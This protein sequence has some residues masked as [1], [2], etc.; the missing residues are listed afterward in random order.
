MIK[1]SNFILLFFIYIT[2]LLVNSQDIYV[3][4]NVPKGYSTFD[5]CGDWNTPC[6]SIEDAGKRAISNSIASGVDQFITIVGNVD[7]TTSASFSNL[8]KY[9]GTLNI[10]SYNNVPVTIDGSS[11]TTPFITIEENEVVSC[12]KKRRYIFRFLQFENWDQTLAKIN[13]NQET[14]LASIED[15]KNV[16]IA[17]FNS[18]LTS[19]SSLS[20]IYPKNI[21]YEY[22]QIA[23]SITFNTLVAEKLTS[24]S[25]LFAPNSI[26]N[27]LPPVYIVGGTTSFYSATF[28]DNNFTTTP[29]I[30]TVGG[31]SRFTSSIV[32]NNSIFC[33]PFSFANAAIGTY[34]NLVFND[35]KL[36][37]LVQ[38]T[39]TPVLSYSLMNIHVTLNTAQDVPSGF[40]SINQ[41]L[42]YTFSDS[43]IVVKDSGSSPIYSNV[44]PSSSSNRIPVLIDNSNVSFWPYLNLVETSFDFNF[45]NSQISLYYPIGDS[46]GI[47]RGSNST[48]MLHSV[49]DNSVA[50]GCS[51]CH[52]DSMIGTIECPIVTP[53]P[54]TCMCSCPCVSSSSSSL[55]S[56]SFSL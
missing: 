30:Y 18:K 49:E 47:I 29:F 26:T 53:T 50:C 1:L 3:N 55:S 48:I 5:E 36:T 14:N 25:T 28:N 10:R 33:T 16:A 37:T 51:N 46:N 13:I 39:G 8:Y 54:S 24:S 7:G 43:F 12:N 44:Y 19:I 23:T 40:C 21:G 17:F 2:I 45:V 32:F 35:Y 38:A 4:Y 22:N 56:S 52:F 42:G 11:S 27:Y 15:S 6:V 41:Y 31:E 20:L 34:R 9:C